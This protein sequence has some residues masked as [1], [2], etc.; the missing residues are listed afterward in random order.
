MANNNANN[1]FGE[2]I[3]NFFANQGNTTT[4]GKTQVFNVVILDRSGSMSSIRQAALSGFN[5]TLRG[6]QQAQKQFA[7]TQDHFVSLLTFCSCHMDN[8]YDKTP[9]LEAREL[10]PAD[11]EPCCCTPL[12]DA[13]GLTITSMRDYVKNIP[14]ATVVVT[15][16]TDGMENASREYS[17]KAINNLVK[18]LRKEGWTFTYM[19]TNQDVIEEA[20]KM[21]I[22]NTRSFSY[23]NDGVAYAM[24]ADRSQRMNF[25][26]RMD[27][28]KRSG[29]P[30]A[31]K[32]E[33]AE[34]ADLAYEEEEER[35]K[36][37]GK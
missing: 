29:G 35:N 25:Y 24:E 14:D 30:R 19:G 6:I 13:M 3:K 32:L 2:K 11:Y 23:N 31:S 28:R 34:M 27:R 36:K 22:N 10:T 7:E 17:A 1:S 26:G 18:D 5:E 12:Y 37:K 16:I 8:V 20:A 9:A 33:L 21:A 4:S 15:I